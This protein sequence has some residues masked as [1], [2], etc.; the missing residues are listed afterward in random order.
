MKK[1]CPN[2][3]MQ[4]DVAK[5]LTCLKCDFVL[6]EHLTDEIHEVDVCHNGEDWPTAER[7]IL[8]A[9]GRALIG[10]FAG[11]RIIHGQGSRR[12]HTSFIRNHSISFA[13]KLAKKKNYRII[14]S[15]KNEGETSLLFA[16]RED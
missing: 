2:C 10:G 1:D 11:L 15:S 7:K 6:A 3:G 12:G 5:T 9:L 13:A 14:R 8:D 16:D 4:I